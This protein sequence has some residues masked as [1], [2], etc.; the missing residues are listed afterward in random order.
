MPPKSES[1]PRAVRLTPGGQPEPFGGELAAID[2]AIRTCWDRTYGHKSRGLAPTSFSTAP[3][4]TLSEQAMAGMWMEHLARWSYYFEPEMLEGLCKR[5]IQG[6]RPTKGQMEYLTTLKNTGDNLRNFFQ[7]FS[8]VHQVPTV[9]QSLV[10][11]VGQVRDQ[12]R[13]GEL[14][15]AR[16]QARKLL[17]V[18]PRCGKV[19]WPELQT[20]PAA[21]AR[22]LRNRV[23]RMK[24]FLALKTITA[25]DFHELKKDLRLVYSVYYHLYPEEAHASAG[26]GTFTGAKKL[27]KRMHQVLLEQKYRRGIKYRTTSLSLPEDFRA[28]MLRF[29]GTIKITSRAS[30]HMR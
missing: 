16:K 13:L 15:R 29:L 14:Q 23:T 18:V 30:T 1:R 3:V 28:H 25:Y 4:I 21:K 12:V 7:L 9:I 20:D 19:D 10:K 22:F 6:L 26:P 27:I 2:E 17:D 11:I 8:V 5:L 24:R